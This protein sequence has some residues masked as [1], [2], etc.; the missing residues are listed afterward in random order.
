MSASA[1]ASQGD[2]NRQ[3]STSGRRRLRCCCRCLLSRGSR[4]EVEFA[5]GVGG[6]CS[7]PPKP[8]QSR[9]LVKKKSG[10]CSRPSPTTQRVTS[11]ANTTET[12]LSSSPE[13]NW[14]A[15]R[16][17]SH[18][19]RVLK[20]V[21]SLS[22]CP[23]L[24][25][26]VRCL[27]TCRCRRCRPPASPGLGWHARPQPI[28]MGRNPRPRQLVFLLS[29]GLPSSEWL[30]GQGTKSARPKP[31]EVQGQAGRPSRAEVRARARG[32]CFLAAGEKRG[33]E[34]SRAHAHEPTG[35]YP[36]GEY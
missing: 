26:L 31:E 14:A 32:L 7:R 2:A 10:T 9:R 13:L 11:H 17:V 30:L 6:V 36:G 1:S 33:E 34:Q 27:P 16:V 22:T 5:Q 15:Q 21:C 3:L 4:P 8:S 25:G 12:Q 23:S 28:G 35:S 19:G 18:H 29:C 24:Q 20:L